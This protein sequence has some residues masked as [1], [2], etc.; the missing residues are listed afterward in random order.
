MEDF[1]PKKFFLACCIIELRTNTPSPISMNAFHLRI[2]HWPSF[3]QD[4]CSID[5]ELSRSPLPVLATLGHATQNQKLRRIT[6]VN[7]GMYDLRM[8]LK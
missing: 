5:I 2:V 6:Q 7:Q 3:M 8:V 4:R 1:E